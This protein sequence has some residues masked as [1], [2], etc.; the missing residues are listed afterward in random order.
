[1]N[2]VLCVEDDPRLRA[3]LLSDLGDAGFDAVGVASAEEVVP[4]LEGQAPDLLLLDVRLPGMSGID[5]VRSAAARG[6][7]PPTI[8][9]SGEATISETIEGLRLGVLDFIEK[10]FGRERLLT[11]I[12]NT[13]ARVS[14]ERDVRALRAAAPSGQELLGDSPAMCELR[15]RIARAAAADAQV[16]IRGPSGSGKELVAAALHR[17]S[18]RRERPFVKLN[19]AAIAPSLVEDELFGHAR[20]AFTGALASKP[21]LFEEADT[22]VLLL[23]EVGDMEVGLQ[24][25]LLRV[26]EDGKVRRIGETR[27]REVNVRVIAATNQ[28]IDELIR[29]RRF[30]EDLYYRLAHLPIDVP[31][32]AGRREDIRPL[33]A[34][35]MA[36]YSRQH[37]VRSRRV[38]D[39]AMAL[40][41]RHA[42]PGN[43]RELRNVCERLVVFGG[44]P[45]TADQLPIELTSGLAN[46]AEP[47]L[48]PEALPE[49]LSLSVL[50]ERCEREYIALVLQRVSWNVAAAARLL[51]LNRTALH[52]KL[53][54]LGMRRPAGNR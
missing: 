37:H 54:D 38:D 44:D 19:C 15:E 42:W 53:A 8:V 1:M 46:P 16:L 14:L 7:L 51:G 2:R 6:V 24:A 28:N 43:V 26:L 12:G 17:A 32:L 25:R 3:A 22:G 33:V 23:D 21:G 31:P 52:D 36:L 35:F 5:L 34:H 13:L 29:S 30:R 41:E 10:P 45:I 4:L 27:E 39:T 49:G 11:S 18:G 48:R 20:G 9:I 40:L 50:R 47:L